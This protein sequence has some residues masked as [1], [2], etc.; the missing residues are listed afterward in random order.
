MDALNKSTISRKSYTFRRKYLSLTSSIFFIKVFWKLFRYRN[1]FDNLSP[2][3]PLSREQKVA[4]LS[5]EDRNLVV[6]GAGTGK[7]SLMIAKAGYLIKKKKIDIDKILLLSFGKEPQ[8][9]LE[10]R[11]IELLNEN[12]NA[13]TFHSYG[14]QICEEVTGSLNVTPLELENRKREQLKDSKLE[15][16]IFHELKKIDKN[17]QIYTQL[18]RYFSDY[19]VPP[20]NL[21]DDTSFQ[22]LNEYENYV[23]KI[24]KLTLNNE[25]VKS[26]GELRV[27]N[28]LAKNGVDYEYEKEWNREPKLGNRYL[29]DF[30]VFPNSNDGIIIEY[31]GVD[32]QNNTKPGVLPEK[33]N[34][35]MNSKIEFHENNKT[36]FIDLY[37][38]DLQEGNLE[39]KLENELT[40]YG[41]KLDPIPV[42]KLIAKFNNQ[43]YFDIF[44]KLSATF[45]RQFK[46]NQ[47]SIVGL[48]EKFNDNERFLAY[49]DIFEFI[50]EKYQNHLLTTNTKDF[51]DM[52][53]EAITLLNN[54]KVQRKL[55]WIIVDEFQDISKGRTELVN[56]LIKQNPKVKILV[57]GDDW[58]SIYRFAGSDI[59]LVQKFEYFFGNTIEMFLSK[60]FR[61]NNQINEFSKAF[62]MDSL[63]KRGS[64]VQIR[65]NIVVNQYVS[66]KK[67]FLHWKNKSLRQIK[68]LSLSDIVSRIEKNSPKDKL[69]ILAR[70]NHNLPN[71]ESEE[72]KKIKEIWGENFECKSIH[73]AK[74][75]EAEYVIIADLIGGSWSFP[76]EQQDDPLLGMVLADSDVKDLE[77]KGEERRLFY[78]AVTRAKHEVHLVSDFSNP[79]IFVDEILSYKNYGLDFVSLWSKLDMPI[80]C[81]EIGCGGNIVNKKCSNNITCSFEAPLCEKCSS[82]CMPMSNKY[83]CTNEE[84][85]FEYLKCNKKRDSYG[86]SSCN[87]VMVPRV[88]TN[89]KPDSKIFLGCSFF[90]SGYCDNV[91]FDFNANCPKCGYGVLERRNKGGHKSQGEPFV[92]CSEFYSEEKC[93]YKHVFKNGIYKNSNYLID[94]FW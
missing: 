87:G 55:D 71:N 76:S 79:S 31:F 7:T 53:N 43:G 63:Y 29:P 4:T 54:N 19:I 16:F 64:E 57:V 44:S 15:K 37:Y 68:E 78:V 32:R 36:K 1:F 14:K 8:Q 20:P 30:T 82:P 81:P 50:L 11:G 17:A 13:H 39:R 65:K 38:Y 66:D 56:S 26:Y 69:L 77:I 24:Q 34:W 12:L 58:Q 86:S 91:D 67:I 33:Y 61:F 48:R 89:V 94:S 85:Y 59:N 35:Q 27:A 88:P 22:T 74:G 73:K 49:L 90:N 3:Y 62:I 9:I 2:K 52:I 6:A 23:K 80:P 21:E 5:E 75:D 83:K 25:K 46:S 42:E 18:I 10:E 51:S 92:G 40:K 47:H 60:S 93:D 45:L 84:C 72:M 70:Y 41:V 28:F